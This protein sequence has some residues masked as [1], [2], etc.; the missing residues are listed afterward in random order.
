MFSQIGFE[1]AAGAS[2]WLPTP[3]NPSKSSSS[4]SDELGTQEALTG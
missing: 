4:R 3:E 2:N 1:E